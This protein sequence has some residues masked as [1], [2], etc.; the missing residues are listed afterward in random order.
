MRF[1]IS[2]VV[3]VSFA[4]VWATGQAHA[5]FPIQEQTIIAKQ[6]QAVTLSPF[7]YLSDHYIAGRTN[8]IYWQGGDFQPVA[9]SFSLCIESQEQVFFWITQNGYQLPGSRVGGRA[10]PAG[11]CFSCQVQTRVAGSDIFQLYVQAST[12]EKITITGGNFQVTHLQK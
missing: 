2:I 9:I 1:F 6:P 3:F 10:D 8:L 4:Q 12:D 11:N 7:G 5:F